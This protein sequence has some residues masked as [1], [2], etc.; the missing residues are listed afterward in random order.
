MTKRKLEDLEGT[1]TPRSTEA[2]ID[3]RTGSETTDRFETPGEKDLVT[4][5]IASVRGSIRVGEKLEPIKV[6]SATEIATPPENPAET[7]PH[8]SDILGPHMHGSKHQLPSGIK[9]RSWEIG[10][11]AKLRKL[12]TRKK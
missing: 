9:V 5:T 1:P 12:T 10:F 3:P 8:K 11:V 4:F 7:D 6:E 2:I